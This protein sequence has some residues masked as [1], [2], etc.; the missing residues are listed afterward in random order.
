MQN[1]VSAYCP[2]GP[3]V[4]NRPPLF[5]DQDAFNGEQWAPTSS[6]PNSWIMVGTTDGD[7]SS[8][9]KTHEELHDNKAP[10]WGEDG[11]F[12]SMKENIM[13]CVTPKTSGESVSET[14][15][16]GSGS[17]T[18]SNS[19]SN[20]LTGNSIL[21]ME[22]I[23]QNKLKP[24]W[25][26][27]GEGW[28]GGSHEDAMAF[29]KT[30]RGKQLCP[31]SAYCPHGAGQPVMGRHKIDFN[32]EGELYAPVFGNEN[33]WVMIGQKGGN[34]ATTCMSHYQLEGS[35]PSWGLTTERSELKKYVMCCTMNT[36]V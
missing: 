1:A 7:V 26:G 17:E 11:L 22:Q 28:T 36:S 29:C 31:Y 30:I 23:M 25:L 27:E 24:L 5:L 15:D 12:T 8:T 10:S 32:A 34:S 18:S 20:T 33:H 19:P 21:D 35:N 16:S 3:N 2:N 6:H 4:K 9:C 14:D 13:C